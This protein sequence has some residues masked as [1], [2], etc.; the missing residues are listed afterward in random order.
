MAIDIENSFTSTLAPFLDAAATERADLVV[1]GLQGGA[2][3]LAISQ[4]L[5]EID[6]PS[7]IVVKDPGAT[8]SMLR[9]LTFFFGGEESEEALR[10]MHYPALDV[11]PFE[12]ISPHNAIL[13]RRM[14][15]LSSLI[16]PKSN[17]VIIAPVEALMEKVIPREEFS[18]KILETFVDDLFERDEFVQEL[19]K[20]GY[21]LVP[22][23]EDIG[24]FS[25]RGEIIDVFCPLYEKPF[26]IVLDDIEVKSIRFFDPAT[27]ISRKHVSRVK[28]CPARQLILNE[29]TKENF[30]NGLKD[31]SDSL[32]TPKQI[33]D[34]L[35]EQIEQSVFFP[36]VE[37]FLPLFYESLSSVFEYLPK[38]A[39]VF[40]VEPGEIEAARDTFLEKV[41]AR[42]ARAGDA[43]KLVCDVDSLYL[44]LKE[45]EKAM[46]SRREIRIGM[47]A[48]ASKERSR[49]MDIDAKTHQGLR[50]QIIKGVDSPEPLKPLLEKIRAAITDRGRVIL[51]C[52]TSSGA[53]RMERILA[54]S[55]FKASFVKGETFNESLAAPPGSNKVPILLGAL[56][57]GFVLPGNG[58]CIICE[59]EIFGQK[60]RTE[61]VKRFKGEVLASFSDISEDDYIVHMIHGVGVYRGLAQIEVGNLPGEYLLLEYAKGDKLYLPVH[62]LSQVHRFVGAGGTP[63]IDHLGGNLWEKAKKKAKAAARRIAKELLEIFAKRAAREGFAMALPDKSFSEFESTFEYDET[64]DQI[65]TIT[66]VIQ[67]MT[68]SR[69]MDRL[70]CGDVG[71]GKTEIALRGAFLAVLSGKQVAVLVPTTTLA[72]QHHRTFKARLEP[73]GAQVEMLSRFTTAKDT[74]RIIKELEQKKVDVVV[75]THKLLGS[76]IKFGDIGL[77]VVDEEQHF[78]V[79]QKEKIKKIK[80][81][82][83]VLSM[84]ATPIPRTLNMALS[85]IRDLSVINTPPEDRLS[86][87]TF[88]STWDSDTISE[89]ISRELQRGGQVFFVHNRIR[90]LDS[91]AAKV[92]ALAPE[93]KVKMVHGQM[94]AKT[95]EDILIDFADN[96][97]DILVSTA[98]IESGLDFPRA[99]TIIIHRAD[100]FGLSQ[101]YQ[102]RGRVGRSKRRAYCYL[103][104]PGDKSITAKARKRLSVIRTF[105]ELGSGYKI[106]ARDLEI[107]GAGNLLGEQQSGQIDAVG[108]EMFTQLLDIEV[109]KLKGIDV[110]ETID[111]EISIQVPAFLPEDYVSDVAQ[112]LSIYKRMSDAADYDQLEE[113]LDEVN[114]RF[115]PPP[116]QVNNL[117]EMM[118]IKIRAKELCIKS[119]ESGPS[120]IIFSFDDRTCVRPSTLISLAT[121]KTDKFK[122][123]P[124]GRLVEKIN[125]SDAKELLK[126][127]KKT[128]HRMA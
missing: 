82:V 49:I 92:Q 5:A 4:A 52:S 108:F 65:S 29:N 8:R 79:V 41:W 85:G 112:R 58:L 72:F 69:P 21:S 1:S 39:R 73:F 3:S 37:F 128:L 120:G 86:I 66:D 7:L 83:D 127:L 60:R 2:V 64:P 74:K 50:D 118:E 35:V 121:E 18:T 126:A 97:I 105:T 89:A 25:V 45:F 22:L 84:T 110:K 71:F 103:V 32:D 77:M 109:K 33:R 55:E 42:R 68:V 96:K 23:T 10:L 90:T 13:G 43:G 125:A 44:S 75:G 31:L 114:D 9:D 48:F 70:V 17:A 62:R 24:D 20:A 26:R 34:Q 15:A 40:V 119:I 30:A 67:D 36:G 12:S 28:I 95:V 123:F 51:V 78:G 80:E 88:V 16:N 54:T 81:Q 19:V 87:R 102:L 100:M 76:K 27:Q 53:D 59:D 124:D 106:A 98:I 38:D 113:I 57:A 99:N 101:L 104:I 11:S 47:D 56:S 115:G 107:R 116:P 91:L 6:S 61:S 117:H 46:G 14:A 93:A 122:L 94:D 111:P 63:T